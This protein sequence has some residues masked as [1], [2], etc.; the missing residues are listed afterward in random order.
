M[1]K[2]EAAIRDAES[3]KSD[4]HASQREQI[5]INVL[6]EKLHREHSWQGIQR[7]EAHFYTKALHEAA[8]DARQ[9]LFEL[10]K[11]ALQEAIYWANKYPKNKDIERAKEKAEKELNNPK[12]THERI[13]QVKDELISAIREEEKIHLSED[14]RKELKSLEEAILVAEKYPESDGIKEALKEAKKV[15]DAVKEGDVSLETKKEIS[16]AKD[17]L[18][19]EL[20]YALAPATD[21]DVRASTPATWPT[22]WPWKKSP[23]A[24]AP[25]PP[26]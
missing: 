25:A 19:R 4:E 17:K 5:R 6:L 8:A 14:I 21:E 24:T 9:S 23:P 22:P 20:A 2:L 10:A 18:I 12:T 3:A 11:E 1:K 7:W 16:E 26:S 15:R 13:D